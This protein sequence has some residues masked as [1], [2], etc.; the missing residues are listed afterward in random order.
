[1]HHP[2]AI[3]RPKIVASIIEGTTMVWATMKVNDE[4]PAKP[5]GTQLVAQVHE[6]GS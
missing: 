6:H 5:L 2:A 1:M 3:C 4:D